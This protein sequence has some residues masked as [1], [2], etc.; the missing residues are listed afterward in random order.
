MRRPTARCVTLLAALGAAWQPSTALAAEDDAQLWLVGFVRTNLDDDVF[1]TIDTSLRFREDAIGPNQQT[2]RATIEQGITKE[3]RLGG[4][5][6][7]FETA[8]QTEFR[9]FQQ[10]R[11]AKGGLDLRTRFEQRMFPG[12]DRA[13]LRFRQRA[14]YTHEASDKVD[15]IGSVEWFTVVQA[16]DAARQTG[17]EQVRGYVGVAVEVAKGV[18]LQPGYVLWYSTREGRED[19][20]SHISQLALNYRF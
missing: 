5:L 14:Q 7:I 19:G 1:L 13:E 8:G 3:V 18:E 9:P 11:Y 17:T 6:A 2:I 4:G 12:A 16:R 20:I 10:F 15:L